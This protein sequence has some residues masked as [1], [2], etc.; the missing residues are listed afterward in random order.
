MSIDRAHGIPQR[1]YYRWT[2]KFLVLEKDELF[3][4]WLMA[5]GIITGRGTASLLRVPPQEKIHSFLRD[6]LLYTKF[7]LIDTSSIN[8]DYI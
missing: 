4:K 5:I 2:A 7:V 3:K 1:R 8:C 6:F